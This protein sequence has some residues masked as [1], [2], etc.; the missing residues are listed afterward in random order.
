MAILPYLP[1][2]SSASLPEST[3]PL[4]APQADPPPPQQPQ[5]A[6]PLAHRPPAPTVT[7]KR[8]SDADL[9]CSA[10]VGKG[11]GLN[12]ATTSFLFDTVITLKEDVRALEAKVHRMKKK[13]RSGK[14]S[15]DIR[16]L[17]RRVQQLEDDNSQLRNQLAHFAAPSSTTTAGSALPSWGAGCAAEGARNEERPNGVSANKG[18]GSLN[19]EMLWC[20]PFLKQ[21]GSSLRHFVVDDMQK[22]SVAIDVPQ[23]RSIAFANHQ[24]CSLSGFSLAEVI[25]RQ[26]TWI[27]P[28]QE[29]RRLLHVL[30][31]R[32]TKLSWCKREAT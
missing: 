22:A 1:P 10:S 20:F 25:G 31:F 15:D 16:E 24:F 26:L 29:K 19:A 9:P 18:N 6:P 4:P 21:H 3:L 7:R 13:K 5:P 30:K 23:S 14:T 2:T 12:G 27:L 8:P 11:L 17:Q 28:L 32:S